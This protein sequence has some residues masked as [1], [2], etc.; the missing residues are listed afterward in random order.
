MKVTCLEPPSQ[1]GLGLLLKGSKAEVLPTAPPSCPHPKSCRDHG[2]P[3]VGCEAVRVEAMGTGKRPCARQGRPLAP[4]ESTVSN[5]GGRARGGGM[6]GQVERRQAG[7]GLLPALS[8]LSSFEVSGERGGAGRGTVSL[9]Y[10]VQRTDGSGAASSVPGPTWPW[11][12]HSP[13][14][15]SKQPC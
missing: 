8:G 15:P 6:S 5:R 13:V 7:E 4:L 14:D 12:I 10:R 1:N 3:K 9:E 11:N 2:V